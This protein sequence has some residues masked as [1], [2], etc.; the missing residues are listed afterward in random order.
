MLTLFPLG[1]QVYV[2]FS[3][4]VTAVLACYLRATDIEDMV[5]GPEGA[6]ILL[7]SALCIFGPLLIRQAWR[8]HVS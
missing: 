5:S 2:A 4:Q 8:W 6:L 3:L 7:N 1:L